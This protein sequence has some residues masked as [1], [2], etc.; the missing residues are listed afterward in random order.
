M[1]T[2]L[3]LIL[4]QDG[5]PFALCVFLLCTYVEEKDYVVNPTLA[6]VPLHH[7]IIEAFAHFKCMSMEVLWI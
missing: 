6:A 7:I 4:R 2:Q 3:E 1:F 5:S